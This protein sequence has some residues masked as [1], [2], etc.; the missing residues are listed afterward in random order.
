[1]PRHSPGTCLPDL[2]LP[3]VTLH[4]LTLAYRQVPAVLIARM[5][6]ARLACRTHDAVPTLQD[7]IA[8][9]VPVRAE[10]REGDVSLGWSRAAGWA[11]V[12]DTA[13]T[14]LCMP[15]GN[16]LLVPMVQASV[17]R[18]RR[19]RPPGVAAQVGITA[20]IF[21]FWLPVSAALFPP[22]STLSVEKLEPHLRDKLRATDSSA[23][24]VTYLRGV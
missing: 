3:Y 5:H 13:L 7:D 8:F 2:T 12:R 22:V 6:T 15:I 1:M 23:E 9:G 14:R 10:T 11:A 24:H 18:A 4:Y 16:F 20:F 19:G 17:E 21:T